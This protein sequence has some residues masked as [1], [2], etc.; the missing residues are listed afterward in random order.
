MKVIIIGSSNVDYTF[1]TKKLPAPGETILGKERKIAGGGKGANQAIAVHRA[2]AKCLFLTALGK[3]NDASFLKGLFEQEA[4]PYL[5]LEKDASTGNAAIMV[6]ESS[7][8]SIIVVGGANQEITK[9]DIQAHEDDIADADFLLLQN[10]IP[11]E[12]ILE[13]ARIAKK[14]GTKVIFN[15]APMSEIPDEL[16]PLLDYFTPNEI[17]LSMVAPEGSLEERAKTLLN[18]GVKNVIVTLGSKGSYYQGEEGSFMTPSFPIKPIDT[19]GAGDT[20]NGYFVASLAL[21][22]SV[23]DSL[24]RASKAAA[25]ACTKQGAIPSIPLAKEI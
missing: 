19:V 10:E 3:D 11:M 15:P 24:T 17:E 1:Y 6:D 14:N 23:K 8:N 13:S 5:A 20:F 22:Y 25:L 16:W 21:G 2:G 4:L 12:A 7:E 9:E 18:K